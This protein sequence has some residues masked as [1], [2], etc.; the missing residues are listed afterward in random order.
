MSKSVVLFISILIAAGLLCGSAGA[1]NVI[2][3][4]FY[5][6][7]KD[8]YSGSNSFPLEGWTIY[9][10]W[11]NGT[12]VTGKQAL[13]GPDGTYNISGVD[14]FFDYY[15][16]EVLKPGWE[17]T[18]PRCQK[19]GFVT[20]GGGPG[21]A[22]TYEFFTN[23]T[24]LNLFMRNLPDTDSKVL[25]GYNMRLG[26]P[27]NKTNEDE[28]KIFYPLGMWSPGQSSSGLSPDG[29]LNPWWVNNTYVPFNTTWVP[30]PNLY[31]NASMQ[32]GSN[33]TAQDSI[34]IRNQAVPIRDIVI[35]LHAEKNTAYTVQL[36]NLTLKQ[37]SHTYTLAN[38]FLTFTHIDS[39]NQDLY[40]VIRASDILTSLGGSDIASGG[41]SL[42]GDIRFIWPSDSA[43]KENDMKVDIM[44]GRYDCSYI[45]EQ[46]AYFGNHIN[47]SISGYKL[48]QNDNPLANWNITAYNTTRNELYYDITDAFGYYNISNINLSYYWLNETLQE[49]F[50][51]VTPNRTV[52]INVTTLNLFN[53]N[54]TNK[55][56]T[57][58]VEGYKIDNCTGQGLQGWNITAKDVAGALVGNTTTNSSGWYQ[59]CNLSSGNHTI[60]EDLKAGWTNVS[61]L[62]REVNITK[63]NITD[64]NFTNTRLLCIEGYKIDNATGNGLPGWNIT[65]YNQTAALTQVTTNA[66]GWYRIC[67]LGPG[68]YQVC[69]ELKS[70]Y[71]NLT[72]LCQNVTLNCSNATNVNF[73]NELKTYCIE[74]YKIDNCTRMGLEGWNITVRNETYAEVGN[75]TTN[76]S[77][78]YR[79]C[80]LLPGD[81]VACEEL[82]AGWINVTPLIECRG[83][84]IRTEN[85]TGINFTNTRLL[86]IEG[87]KIDNTTGNGLPGWNITVSNQ[88]AEIT[89]VMTNSSGWYQVCGLPPGEYQVCEE[90]K[91]GFTNVSQVCRNITLTCRNGTNVNFTNEAETYC[92]EG[93]KIDNCS[94]QGLEDW[95]VTV[96][97]V[98]G[99]EVGNAT[100]DA[101]GWYRICGLLPGDY[102][103]CEELKAGWI[104][105]S[106]LCQNVT[107]TTVNVT[108]A[109]FTNTRL[110]CIEGYKLDY[111]TQQGLAGWNISLSN[112]TMFLEKY[113]T[114]ATGWYQFCGLPPG[115]YQLCEELKPG[116]V[117]ITPLCQNITLT[118]V[119][120]TEIYF[121]NAKTYCINGT[122]TN[123]SGQENDGCPLDGWKMTVY[124]ETSD[125]EVGNDTTDINGYY[126][127]CGLVPGD[128]WI[129]EEERTGFTNMTPACRNFTIEDANVTFDI[130]NA[131]LT[132]I[133][134]WKINNA[135]GQGLEGW[136]IT[137]K[138]STSGSLIGWDLT[139]ETGYFQICDLTPGYNY[140]VCE[141]LK[142][143]WTP[144]GG[145]TCIIDDELGCFGDTVI[146]SNDP[147]P[148]YCIVGR[149]VDAHTGNGLSGWNITVTGEG[150]VQSNLTIAM[151]YYT[152]CG[153]VPGDY[154]VCE[155]LQSGWVNV[156]PLC[157]NIT[158]LDS[159]ET[160]PDF[161]NDPIGNVSGHKYRQGTAT[162]LPGWTIRLVNATTDIV[163]ATTVTLSDGSFSFINVPLGPYR[164]EEIPQAGWTQVTPNTTVYIDMTNR[165][166]TY[167][168]Y[169]EEA[170]SYC[171]EC[172]PNAKFTYTKSGLTATFQDTSTGPQTAKW[173]WIFGDGT[174]SSEQNPAHTYARS[175]TYTVRLYIRWLDCN[176]V[177]STYWKSYYQSVTV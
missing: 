166:V 146:F 63:A 46:T 113:S 72:P 102:Y 149:K 132:C 136:N 97:D 71:Q 119:N 91:A 55:E 172:P 34:H 40:L 168:F 111:T 60:C 82:K 8:G 158:I 106:S 120:E 49:G 110:L 1:V 69:E 104:N 98:T 164:L 36:N 160:V 150:I 135:T 54:F 95:N 79:I 76:S 171:C 31:S 122:K 93:Y 112:E 142:D 141:E 170:V 162:G 48:D 124:N 7:N 80:G 59:I 147:P 74:G 28:F 81:Y 159:N 32:V 175:G 156:S 41:F 73:T 101:T 152:I 53:Q 165:T 25:L 94:G 37:G 137:V 88:T 125:Q 15:V 50:T 105:I 177:M 174:T 163:Y 45:N 153:L 56:T 109:N 173:Y 38:S 58:C 127:I 29:P 89:T 161:V 143:G 99:A 5:D 64:I 18:T 128:Y 114:N 100:T 20:C 151:G 17:N 47:G 107:I 131:K 140:T 157:Y 154:T 27:G 103:V 68:E 167:D 10:T 30:G 90:L 14:P 75:A 144:V 4:K 2:G 77:G 86:C 84:T 139:N 129:C 26:D 35:R 67:G 83:F 33:S 92:I 117:N 39:N 78:W 23:D 13:T 138:N 116:Y 57:Y 123:C 21:G 65:V 61:P 12:N 108:D 115:E 16:C 121:T 43:P 22:G 3:F 11:L 87:Y 6:Y 52:Q 51:Q 134:G 126:E 145:S 96:Q 148:L 130:R 9:L 155:E 42:T 66:T 62:C 24:Q 19:I 169:N 85:V 44:V 118:C 133:D 70:E 176:G